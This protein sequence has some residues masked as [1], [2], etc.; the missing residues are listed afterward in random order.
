MAYSGLSSTSIDA[1]NFARREQIE[2][3]IAFKGCAWAVDIAR[4]C[5]IDIFEVNKILT[6]LCHTKTLQV[7]APFE[8]FSPPPIVMARGKDIYIEN[9]NSLAAEHWPKKSFFFFS[10]K[11]FFEWCTKQKGKGARAHTVYLETYNI[12]LNQAPKDI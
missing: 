11:G 3:Y 12:L 5:L 8:R 9:A 6:E 7:V 1:F 4:H 10:E 2:A